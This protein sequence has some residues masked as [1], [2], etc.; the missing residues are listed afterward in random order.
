[1]KKVFKVADIHELLKQVSLGEISYSRMVE[2]MNE[3]A[4]EAYGNNSVTF[5]ED[6]SKEDL[7]RLFYVRGILNNRF[8]VKNVD[9]HYDECL[10]MMKKAFRHG[11]SIG[12]IRDIAT[13]SKSYS[14]FIELMKVT[15]AF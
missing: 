2:I 15:N 6:I 14:N 7:N 10:V 11:K 4:Y 5:D 8:N 13:T 9:N 3:M 1:M 12:N